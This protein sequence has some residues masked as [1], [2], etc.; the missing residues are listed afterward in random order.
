MSIKKLFDKNKQA[1]TVSK[2]LK[3]SAPSTLGDGI[4][5]AGH[6]SESLQKTSDFIPHVNYA[7]P[8]E[9]VHFGS[10]QRY[11]ENAFSYITSYYPYDGSGEE[12]EAFYNA[13]NPLE[14]YVLEERYPT[15]T[16]YVGIGS[17]YGTLG[18]GSDGYYSSSVNQYIQVKGGPHSGTVYSTGSYRTSNLEFGGPSGTTVEFFYKKDSA[19]DSAT[20]SEKQVIFDLWN[21]ENTGSDGYGRLRIE[22]ISGTE[23]SFYV[24]LRSGTAGFTSQRV[25]TNGGLNLTSSN[26]NQYS[27]VFDTVPSAPAVSKA[28]LDFYVTGN[29]YERDLY[30]VGTVGTVDSGSLIANLGS[31]RT[32]PSA[33]STTIEEGY[34]KLSASLDEFRFWKSNRSP[35]EVG[36]Y[37]FT[38]VYG[39]ADKYDANK[40]LGVYYK[41][42]EGITQTASVDSII[43]D[44]SGRLSNG[45]YVGYNSDT[46]RNTGS[47][48]D[49]ME[50]PSVAEIG[51]P[52]V[53]SYNPTLLSDKSTLSNTGREYDYTN[54]A[55]LMNT[56]PDWITQEDNET[57]G[58]LR[59]I[60]Q[61]M[62]SYL[63]TLSIQIKELSDL[64]HTTYNSGS[65]TGSLNE[66]PYNDRLLDSFGIETPEFFENAQILEKFFQRSE[67]INFDQDLTDIKNAIYKN[68]YNN[69]AYLFKSKGHEKSI[70]NLIRCYGIGEDVLAL[71]IYST[72]QTYDLVTNYKPGVSTKKYVDFSGL[73]NVSSSNGTV[74][75]YYNTS[76]SNSYGLLSGSP[77]MQEHALTVE[78]EAYFPSRENVSTLGYDPPTMVSSSLFGWHTPANESPTN[79]SIGW[80]TSA[81]DLGLQVY[82]VRSPATYS[83]VVAP[84][85]K[86]RDVYF[87][88]QD[89]HGSTLVSTNIFRNV[90]DNE[91]WNF[92]LSIKNDKWPFAQG[93]MGTTMGGTTS[94]DLD[95]YGVN[96]DSGLKRNSFSTNVS[97]NAVTG[98]ASLTSAK[99]FY[100]GSHRTNWTGSYLS[101]SDIRGTS[102]RVWN[103][104]LPT[105]TI[106]LH[107]KDVDSFGN[108]YP[109]QQAYTFQDPSVPGNFIPNIQTLALNWDF[110]NITGT[111]GSGQFWVSDF[112]SGSNTA[113]DYPSQYQG[114]VFSNLNL[115]QHTGRGDFFPFEYDKPAIKQYIYTDKTQLPEYV[116]SSDMVSVSPTD[117]EVFRPNIR[118]DNLYFSVEKSMYRSISNRMLQLM[119]SIDE[120]NRLIGSP[121]N[122]YRPEYKDMKKL[123]EI[124]FRKVGNVPDF[125]K[126]VTFYRWIDLAM[127]EVVAQFFPASSR[128]SGG[129]RTIIE[130]HL[131]ERPKYHWHYLGDRNRDTPDIVNGPSIY[132]VSIC[133]DVPGWKYNHA[134]SPEEQDDNCYWWKSRA[135]RDN[136]V[137][138]GSAAIAGVVA[139][140]D[141]VLKAFQLPFAPAPDP[142]TGKQNR[143]LQVVC[144]ASE[145]DLPYIGGINQSINKA[146]NIRDITFDATEPL[147]DCDDIL[148]PNKKTRIGFRATKDGRNYKGDLI[149]PFSLFSSS[150]DSGYQ[151]TLNLPNIALTNLHEDSVYSYQHS[152]PMQGPFTVEHVGGIQARHVPPLLDNGYLRRESHTL[153]IS[154]LG[155]GTLASIVTSTNTPK[156]QYLR[157]MGSK[158]PLNITNIRTTTGSVELSGAVNIL[159]NF[160]KNYEVVQ[161]SNRNDTNMDF[162]FNNNEY[163]TGSMPSAFIVPP[164]RMALG[165][166]GS[167]DYD[168][169]RQRSNRRT[170]ESIFVERFSAPG[171]KQDS[172]Q[173]YRDIPS[174]QFSSNNA[175]PFRNINVRRIGN[176]GTRFSLSPAYS[177]YLPLGAGAG[178]NGFLHI[179]TGWGGFQQNIEMDLSYLNASSYG[180]NALTWLNDG[181]AMPVSTIPTPFGPAN[182]T[183]ASPGLGALHKTQR[184]TTFRPSKLF[185]P[186]KYPGSTQVD[187]VRDNAFVVRPIPEA[188]RSQWFMSL[189]GSDSDIYTEW[190]LSG[191]RYP[192][193][194]KTNISA[195]VLPSTL[196][197][198]T[199]TGTGGTLEYLWQK[200]AGFSLW[201]ELRSGQTHQ[202]RYFNLNN[203][204]EILPES[205]A[206]ADEPDTMAS[207]PTS[208]RTT[209]DRSGL[210]V[211]YPFY[212]RFKEPPI[213]SKY[214]PLITQFD[215][216]QGT[217]GQTDKTKI[218]QATA[219][220][221]YG[222]KLQGFANKELNLLVGNGMLKYKSG[223]E[224]RPYEI[225][226]DNY[227]EGV[228]ADTTG[229]ELIRLNAYP[230]VVYP[231]EIYT[232]LSGTR[233]RLSFQNHF[234][235]EDRLV[236]SVDVSS[237]TNYSDLR[238]NL[239]ASAYNV[240][241]DRI[242][243][244]FTTSQGYVMQAATQNPWDP[245]DPVYDEAS[246][247]GSASIWAMD[248]YLYAATTGTLAVINSPN[249]EGAVLFAGASTMPC[250]ELMLTSYGTVKGDG[251]VTYGNNEARFQSSSVVS[252]QYIYT[253]PA[254]H[255]YTAG[256]YAEARAPGG[257]Y[258]R[259]FWNV[260]TS[261]REVNGASVIEN[262][263]PFY[264]SYDKF[265]LD[266]RISA[267]DQG[268]IPEFR[269]SEHLDAY[270][271]NGNVLELVSSSLS[272]TGVVAQAT[273]SA[274]LTLI[275][276]FATSDVLQYL[277]P[278][279]EHGTTDLS[280]NKNP[281]HFEMSSQV[282][283]KLL[284]YDGFYPS[285]RSL[286]IAQLFS[287]SY[288]PAAI[289]GG[290]DKSEDA[291]WRT[292]LRPF[293]APGLFYNAIK[294]GM[295]LGFPVSRAD[296]NIN[297]FSTS[298]YDAPLAG[299]LSGSLTAPTSGEIPGNR[300]R[301]GA[302]NYDFSNSDVDKFFWADSLPFEALLNPVRYIGNDNRYVT[303]TDLSPLM[304][305]DISGSLNRKAAI[306]DL[307]YRLAISN[308]LGV[309]P[310]FFLK[311]KSEGGYMTKF[312][313]QLPTPND[314][315][316][317]L[318]GSSEGTPQGQAG[319]V[320]VDSDTAYLMEVGI[321]KTDQY[322]LYSN[323]YAFGI[324]TS[325]GSLDWTNAVSVL[326]YSVAL[327]DGSTVGGVPE[328]FNWPLHRAEFAPFTPAYYYGD[329]YVRLSYAPQAAGYVTL[330][331]IFGQIAVQY[332]NANDAYFDFA[333]GSFRDVGGNTV[334]TTDYPIYEWNRAWQNRQDIDSSIVIDNL[335]PTEGGNISPLDSNKWVIM[336]KW[337]CPMLDY[338]NYDATGVSGYNWDFSSSV[339]VGS[340]DTITQGVWHQYGVMPKTNEGVYLYIADVVDTKGT[341]TYEYRLV[342]DPNGS[343]GSG[344]GETGQAKLV[345]KVP[346]YVAD[347]TK[348][349]S[350]ASLV[351]FKDEDIMPAGAWIPERA[352]RMGELEADDKKTL[353]E[354][355]VA[356]PFFENHKTGELVCMTMTA[357]KNAL[358]PKIKEFRR[359]FTKYS[360][361]PALRQS[362]TPL[363]PA[364]FP[365]IPSFI[366]P[367]GTDSR[368]KLNATLGGLDV[369]SVPVVYLMEHTVALKRQDLSDIWQGVMPQISTV[370]K[371]SFSAIDHY[372][373]G[374]FE[375]H[376]TIFPEILE[377]EMELGIPRNGHPRVDIIDTPGWP[378]QNGFQPKIKWLVFRVKQRGALSYSRTMFEEIND[379]PRSYSANY[380]FAPQEMREAISEDGQVIY[381]ERIINQYHS[382]DLGTLRNTYNWPYDYCS[383]IENGKLITK[384][385]FRPE[386]KKELQEENSGGNLLD[387]V[388]ADLAQS[389]AT[390]ARSNPSSVGLDTER[391]LQGR[392]LNF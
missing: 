146:R 200:S 90:Y 21:G 9:F 264:P 49:D 159:G 369:L 356:M 327:A 16:G 295:G 215:T 180:P 326:G 217:A 305:Y 307:K 163:Y 162:V 147:E 192:L 294:S 311:E 389:A 86:V 360:L 286:Q 106:D 194:I 343:A 288:A 381:P 81:Q 240:D 361:P 342:G 137:F 78:F 386:L 239:S 10:A 209:V 155:T 284:P 290:V 164:S 241:Y 366:D 117:I 175:L 254:E 308:F 19:I 116:V 280:F 187:T 378:D 128:N 298:S 169:P 52:I 83:D 336:P 44:Y 355:I 214:F 346:E 228:T 351:G 53:R 345:S 101:L 171:S 51:D 324:P 152:V 382:D 24:T 229:I 76:D 296:Y 242:V 91:K 350:L 253:F 102:L 121:V 269:I 189:S 250:G 124:F 103:N 331:E 88:V 322:N 306:D 319:K 348:F 26:W 181:L 195:A 258:T 111:D 34:G 362:L 206:V 289:W 72:E 391:L 385:G 69:A 115:R 303:L 309:T 160:T 64:R 59:N 259:P 285:D 107:A 312:V 222:N 113:G 197:T 168:A 131:L 231:R 185:S 193:N 12:T 135:E 110:A 123:R 15:S 301:R 225:F 315:L 40:D 370:V 156:G 251:D 109:Y 89:R 151:A 2:Y 17:D 230:E 139:T 334:T 292:L 247:F 74:Y 167:A 61:I 300:R 299:G 141:T 221:S 114:S 304:N 6:L 174:D 108:I 282:S 325:S 18:A 143:G 387:Q 218:I 367:F 263:Y 105:G 75:Q 191:S 235:R 201:Q 29:C 13:L 297:Q 196:G 358:G 203:I 248:S 79:T 42:N 349:G 36:R 100:V 335:F 48:I 262:R 198:S 173:L 380:E 265:A 376:P 347:K 39:G 158:S 172:K 118:P 279:M 166:S 54:T 268:V 97:L 291:R 321:K 134:P 224:K 176:L 354:A 353:S 249:A 14:Q 314:N 333:S 328:G 154:A 43:L 316:G 140:R 50:I 219:K 65:L 165:L 261:R 302:S 255:S 32:A 388:T 170:N 82:A 329:S 179:Y 85:T 344:G 365:E 233:Q 275:P 211:G 266:A 132:A 80:A 96:Y 338:R 138:G 278:F 339:E 38:H 186:P 30:G 363:L 11:Y 67:N 145:L 62:A 177:D 277:D 142:V 341:P 310:S 359:A 99:R 220:Y 112:S 313:A 126:Y 267:K 20:E 287:Q 184:N 244:P 243:A 340:Y 204:Y 207:I 372:M 157:G 257:A 379:G 27:F 37:W 87:T 377:K 71:N 57:N 281:R 368:D 31:L 330:E 384:T 245:L 122:R 1:L 92:S 252:A 364:E 226:R 323:P 270:K 56:M 7:D 136:P 371:K 41:F 238:N 149:T 66:F 119:A 68:I 271:V 373:P 273:T 3:Q 352:K 63:D 274:D 33:T 293:Y 5:S 182:I 276:R 227:N 35:E 272:L 104:Y 93:I 256:I 94:Y 84:A 374:E 210:V 375:N 77:D 130:D 125:E 98:A 199:I 70:R 22:I 144:L 216:R 23:D 28:T 237:F 283:L 46:S 153:S 161:T 120:M 8:S 95:F 150:V 208:T 232:Y 357:D 25:P 320:Y 337:E 47:A 246:G 332:G 55:Y 318:V 383:L 260:S 60:T 148:H 127:G 190:Q 392:L 178:L 73:S 183:N 188:D 390:L 58:E 234:W 202:G 213:T 223:I 205:R 129:T 133:R 45:N 4:E 317:G 212:E 236:H